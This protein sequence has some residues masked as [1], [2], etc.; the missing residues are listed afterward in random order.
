MAISKHGTTW[1]MMEILR[2][3]THPISFISVVQ[4]NM[5][6]S[7]CKLSNYTMFH[8]RLILAEMVH[9]KDAFGLP[10]HWT[11]IQGT[12]HLLDLLSTFGQLKGSGQSPI[13]LHQR[14][15]WLTR[16]DRIATP[17]ASYSLRFSFASLFLG[18]AEAS[19]ATKPS[20]A[21]WVVYLDISIHIH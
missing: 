6:Q 12:S 15:Q 2:W 1:E 3:P 21:F 14:A 18:T 10:L 20:M 19:K 13:F 16:L 7:A 9:N 11:T 4:W 8:W 17:H 5:T